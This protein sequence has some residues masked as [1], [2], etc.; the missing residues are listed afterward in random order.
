VRT[1]RLSGCLDTTQKTSEYSVKPIEIIP[2]ARRKMRR[3]GIPEDWVLDALRAPDQ[4][5]PGYADRRVAHK[6]VQVMG[7]PMLLR[8]VHEEAGER[9]IF[10]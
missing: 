7:A 5:V 6:R 1:S 3:R 4:I 10:I 8:V 9:I 2:L